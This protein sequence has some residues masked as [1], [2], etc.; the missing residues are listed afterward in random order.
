MSEQV[1]DVII[2]G[3]GIAGSLLASF[4]SPHARV[5][6]LDRSLSCPGSTGHAPGFVGELN[7]IP[8]LTQ[9][10]RRSIDLYRSIPGGFDPVG[11]LEVLQG[12]NWP[13]RTEADAASTLAEREKL[14]QEQGVDA[15]VLLPKEAAG[16]CPA[17]VRP[18]NGGAIR[19]PNDG[20][21][22]AKYI[23]KWGQQQAQSAGATVTEGD[24]TKITGEKDDWK[25]QTSSGEY[26]AKRV[27]VATGI[28][29]SQLAP[30]VASLALSVAHP[31]A[32]SSVRE[33]RDVWGPF[34]RFPGPH[35]YA[36]DHG[37][38]DGLGSYAHDPVHVRDTALAS[39]YGAWEFNFNSVLA[40]A[41]SIIPRETADTFEPI[42]PLP[43]SFHGKVPREAYAFNGLFTVTPDA[44]P[45]FGQSKSG[46]WLAIGAWVT[47]AGGATEILAGEIRRSLGQQVESDEIA[48]KMD[49]K[50]F[51][52]QKAEETEKR[53]LATYNDIYNKEKA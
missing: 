49:P 7:T 34:V 5:L 38:R 6:L 33:H 31:Y 44:L 8:T 48:Q 13:G 30:E 45:L 37:E 3:A 11:G 12:Q 14:A 29:A 53:A 40:R 27:V 24:V 25:V 17:L 43:K 10:A 20:T 32:Y 15:E 9:L 16:L 39:A 36:R 26:R 50:R 51:E 2:V 4:L 41:L 21:A 28:W 35:V 42:K 1:Y 18:D 47:N 52:G 46:V 19:F 23:A 22:N